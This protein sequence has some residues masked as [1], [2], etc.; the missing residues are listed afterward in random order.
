[1]AEF[2]YEKPFPLKAM[3]RFNHEA[4]AVDPRTGIVYLTEDRGD[5]LFYRF[6]PK[7]SGQL[8]KGGQLQ[9]LVIKNKPSYDTRNWETP[10]MKHQEW[11]DTEWINLT[12]PESPEDDLRLRGYKEGAALFARGEGVHWGDQE[13][14]FRCTNGGEKQLGQVMRYSPSI[15]E[16]ENSS[17]IIKNLSVN[18]IALVN[19]LE[20][21]LKNK[22]NS[23]IFYACSSHIYNETHTKIQNENTKPQF[24]SNYALT[25][26][27]AKEICAFYRKKKIFC[28]VGIMYSHASK[29]SKKKFLIKDIFSQ[30]K[31]NKKEIS[32]M[33]KKAKIDLLSVTDVVNA[34]YEI[35][36]LNY[37]DEFIISSNK[38]VQVK[39]VINEILKIKNIK[40]IKIKD[41][42]KNN[43]N[44]NLT[45][46]RGNNNK[47]IK[48]TKWSPKKNLKT[49]VNEHLI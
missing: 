25:K 30:I 4:A 7:V 38:I 11:H 47:L 12:N 40:S 43:K 34:I 23:K 6:I 14:Y 46:L 37:S 42:K 28:S 44:S 1:M 27:L 21:A 33:N 13:L 48:A 29:L 10:A 15:N 45:I 9:A 35:M 32:V 20:Y 41:L 19:F 8:H 49:L 39:D 2:I 22:S 18:I 36:N 3:G 5:S 16:S 31:N 17:I 24:N 26:Y